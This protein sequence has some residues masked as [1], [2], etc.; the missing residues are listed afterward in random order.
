MSHDYLAES[1]VHDPIHGYISFTSRYGLP[2]NEV[3][4]QEI[5]DNPWVQRMRQI[6][7]LQTAWWVF[8]SAEHMRFQ[9]IL[10]AMHLA[11]R[12]I[13]E[14]YDSLVDSCESV[15][16]KPYVESLVR[17][18][19]LLHDVGHGPFGHFFD[20][21]YLDQFGLT[22]EVIG[23]YLIEHELGD[24]LRG[25][26]RNPHG[27]FKPLEVL[28]PK[29]IGWLICRPKGDGDD[30]GHPSWLRKLRSLF[31][32][33][34]TVDNMDFVLRDAYMSGYNT[35]AFDISRLLHYSFF[36]PQGLTIHA[37]GLPTLINFVETRANL[38]RTIYFHRTVRALDIALEELF[39][40]TMKHLFPGNPLEH[41]DEYLHLTELSFLVDI[42]RWSKSSKPEIQELGRKWDAILRRD[43]SW[44]MACE[45]TLNFHT[46]G[47]ARMT[48][49]SEPDLVLRRVRERMPSNLRNMDLRFDVAQHYHRPSARLPVHGQNFLLDPAQGTPSELN[50]DE[51]FRQLPISFLIFRI[52]TQ[53]HGHE[54][55]LNAALNSV[56]GD[57]T[58]A[59]TNM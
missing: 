41:L 21:H 48:I 39:P 7:Q 27:V 11:S 43:V 14:W 20:D 36:T 5:I 18:A 13:D 55:L 49:F 6:H 9:H 33:I 44:K 19:A 50:D 34:Y 2:D 22:H 12:C 57:A 46:A 31:S 28:D 3:S 54:A 1:L 56:L 17:M 8:P 32:G 53:D 30:E 10:G 16:S 59:K 15:P 4:E 37:R 58:D 52:Y 47:A 35:K 42:A 51:L 25:V 45:R 38:F 40:Q 24:L 29:Q 26:R 23:S